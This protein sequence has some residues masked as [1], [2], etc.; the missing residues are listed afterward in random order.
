M[1]KIFLFVLLTAGLFLVGC[2]KNPPIEPTLAFDDTEIA[3]LV[4]ETFTLTPIITE[5][6]GDDLVEYVV[7]NPAVVNFVDDEWVGLQEGTTTITASLKE[8]EDVEVVITVVVSLQTYVLTYHDG[9]ET[10]PVN[11]DENDLPLTLTEPTKSG[12]VFLGWF[13]TAELSGDAITSIDEVGNID[14]YAGWEEEEI[15]FNILYQ[16]NGGTLPEDAPT[17]YSNL[18]LPF[19][20]PVP[21]KA[22]YV[23]VGWYE[24]STFSGENLSVLEDLS[25]Q[26]LAL[27]A[28]YLDVAPYTITYYLNDG[29][30]S[31][32]NPTSYSLV[33]VPLS[34]SPATKSGFTFG[35]WY[36]NPLFRGE[37]IEVI[38]F[39]Q[40]KK[41][42]AKWIGEISVELIDT[43]FNPDLSGTAAGT[44]VNY[45]GVE[46][47]FGTTAFAT[48]V[49]AVNAAT[50]KVLIAGDSSENITIS[51]SNL[52][53]QGPNAYINP[54]TGTRVAEATLSGTITIATNVEKIVINGLA[55]TGAAKVTGTGKISNIQFI[56]NYVHHTAAATAAWIEAAGYTSGFFVFSSSTNYEIKDFVVARNKFDHVSDANLNFIRITNLTVDGNVFHEFDR[57]AIRFDTGGYNQGDFVFT[58]NEFT[59]DTL[60]GYNGIYFRIYGGDGITPT[61][62]TVTKNYFKNIGQ[63]ANL[64]YSGAIS[65][66]NYQEKGATILIQFNEFESCAN[67]IEI[68]N[69]AT[70]LNHAEH[71]WIAIANY[72]IFK[73]IPTT[74]YYRNWVGS[75]SETTNPPTMNME[76]NYFEDGSGN[77][78]TDLAPH[79][80]KFMDMASYANN[81]QSRQEY[82]D[83]IVEMTTGRIDLYVNL[84]WSTKTANEVFEYEG[85]DLTYGVN[86]FSSLQEAI[87][88]AAEGMRIFV[89]PGTYSEAVLINK[90]NLTFFTLNQNIDPNNEIREPEATFSSIISLASGLVGVNINGFAF[91]GSAQVVSLGSVS[92]LVFQYNYYHNTTLGS[93]DTGL[94]YLKESTVNTQQHYRLTINNNRFEATGNPRLVNM[95]KVEDLVVQDN[96]FETANTVYADALRVYYLS[97]NSPILIEG[98]T[99]TKIYQYA[100][101]FS[102]NYQAKQ[103]DIINNTFDTITTGGISI[104]AY[105]GSA[106]VEDKVKV[107][108]LYN[109]FINV[110][111]NAVR[112]D[113]TGNATTSVH[114]I[115]VHYNLFMD[116][117]PQYYFYNNGDG[118][119]ANVDSNFYSEGTTPSAAKLKG[120]ATAINNYATEAETPVYEE[121]GEDVLPTSVNI[122][123]PVSS[124]EEGL[125]HQ[126]QVSVGPANATL[127]KVSYSSSDPSIATVSSSGLVEAIRAGEVTITVVSDADGGVF[128]TMNLQVVEKARIEVR[129]EGNGVLHASENLPLTYHLFFDTSESVNWESSNTAVATVDAAGTVTAVASGVVEITATVNNTTQSATIGLTVVGSEITDPLLLYLIE[130]NTGVIF[131]EEVYYVGS[132]DGSADY[133]N[134][135]YDTVSD[136]HFGTFTIT[137]NMLPT[138]RANYSGV[139]MSSIEFITVHDTAGSGSTS[140]AYA[141]SH[142]CTNTTNTATSWHYTT[143]NDGIFQQLEDTIKGYHAGDGSRSFELVDTGIPASGSE[144]GVVG[145]SPRGFY[146]INGIETTILAPI[147]AQITESGIYTTIGQNGN[148]WMNKAYFNSTYDVLANHGGNNNSIG[149]ETAVN[150]GSDVY[151]TWHRTAKLIAQLLMAHDLET[152]RVLFHN[153]F[154]GK[155]CPRTMLT[156]ELTDYFYQ[157][158]EAEYRILKDYSDYTITLVSNDP[159]IIDHTGRVIGRPQETTNVT[160]TITVSKTGVTQ[161]VT[162]NALVPGQSNW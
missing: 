14:V 37:A 38:D 112:V 76:Y 30:N 12:F 46:Y 148:Y 77:P 4:D 69:N 48:L 154:S 21:T 97:G 123:N 39:A 7:A 124:L 26:N 50:G 109:R 60:K 31:S 94:L 64:Y 141:N 126:L 24:D 82:D 71:D 134:R 79:A 33:D 34:I 81:Y 139:T 85:K 116:T 110:A 140:T 96:Y 5:L 73:G 107:N 53:L 2:K 59:N 47:T 129:Y 106:T 20:L 122:T 159:T 6:T 35:G 90:N 113:H 18:T 147:Y 9:E 36:D 84:D 45:L 40:N 128:T 61:N 68:R 19:T 1:K 62:I 65:M 98:N 29:V 87:T 115:Q 13:T 25:K 150:N 10:T 130:V 157:M 100:I 153:N 52:T 66:R 101:F 111:G 67:Y 8:Y 49:E 125:T 78:I 146:T 160:F 57:D 158:V 92:D 15:T 118:T 104:R 135:I 56:N 72:N 17:T 102:V 74:Y 142:W 162:L 95:D 144:K 70:A 152:D 133:P 132:D 44:A 88:V 99:F 86:A 103:I 149:I 28:R 32:A 3:I 41:L 108:V 121:S 16:V 127:K 136:Y 42:Y 155:P 55:F 91:T 75:D 151:Y 105:T 83:A 63:P 137:R 114:D 22:G 119:A 145:L 117:V 143:G 120:T 54:N 43:Y 93:G 23:F 51:K 161:S 27:Y 11:F 156:H 131:T 58:N 138:D 89:L 80:A